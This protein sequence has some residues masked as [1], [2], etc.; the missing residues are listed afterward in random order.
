MNKLFLKLLILL[1]LISCK[2]ESQSGNWKLDANSKLAGTTYRYSGKESVARVL[3]IS[4]L[5]K[6]AY[7]K[8]DDNG[9][10]SYKEQLE[11][12]L[13][14]LAI[15]VDEMK[16]NEN[17]KIPILSGSGYSEK[18]EVKYSITY[19]EE[20]NKNIIL[21][22]TLEKDFNTTKELDFLRKNNFEVATIRT[23]DHQLKTK[24]ETQN[25][26]KELSEKTYPLPYGIKNKEGKV[27]W[28]GWT[29]QD[30]LHARAGDESDPE[31]PKFAMEV[32][33]VAE[34]GSKRAAINK[35]LEINNINAVSYEKLERMDISKEM[36]GNDMFFAIGKSKLAGK[37]AVLFLRIEKAK[38]KTDYYVLV[39]EI[40]KKTYIRWGG[41]ASILLATQVIK[42]MDSIPKKRKQQIANA[43]PKQQMKIYEAA[44]NS[45]MQQYY[46]GIMITQSQT[47][48]RMQELNYDLLLGGDITD[49]IIGN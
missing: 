21:V 12:A 10:V 46:M 4:E 23:K 20:K 29:Y 13:S 31:A 39:M 43:T 5:E 47:L 25:F 35:A 16:V 28:K 37:D 18:G 36:L 1:L 26:R 40:P 44:Y 24:K 27:Y 33:K 7:R 49:P 45:L 14:V 2:G 11:F 38:N 17:D 34:V 41:I 42:S 32:I 48:L 6:L 15:D 9:R 19:Q 3:S 30:D 8:I 22:I